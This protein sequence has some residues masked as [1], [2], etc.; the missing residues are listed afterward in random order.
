[1]TP[2]SALAFFFVLLLILIPAAVLGLCG[3]SLRWYGLAA[4]VVMVFLIFDSWTSRAVLLGFWAWQTALCFGYL[5]LRRKCEK[6]WVLWL[7]LFASLCPLILVKCSAF[8]ELPNWLSIL[9]ISY[10]TFRAL[11]ILIETY[12]GYIK[13]LSLADFTHFLLFFPS[14]SSG[15]VDRYRRFCEDLAKPIS[16]SDYREQL[17]LGVWKLMQGVLYDFVI[18]RLIWTFWLSNLPDAGFGATVSYMYGYTLYMFFNFAGYSLMA[19]GTAYILG[20]RLPDNF[21]APFVSV[22]M[23]DFWARWHISLSTWLRDYLYTRF[24]MAALKGKWFKNRRTGSYL[25]YFLT[26][27]TMGLWHGLTVPYLVYGVYHGL[28]MSAND[29]LD[30]RVKAFK[31]WKKEPAKKAVLMFVTFHLFSFGLL[32]FS[33]RLF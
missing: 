12:D 25:G 23:K 15:P 10:M 14:V 28:L 31:A 29:V 17:K 18:A 22:D 7:F 11:Q 33:G 8:L 4:T 5:A 24:C 1:M 9:G 32:I 16:K 26:M 13:E 27:I 21:R 30:T 6:R 3:K 2:Y 19:V 20:I